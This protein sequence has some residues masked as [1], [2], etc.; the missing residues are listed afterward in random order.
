[1]GMFNTVASI[2]IFARSCMIYAL[3]RGYPLRFSSKNTIL[4]KYDGLFVE[5]F[6]RIYREEF[7]EKFKAIGIDYEH[8][9]IDDMV[10]QAIKG[11][12]GLVWACKNY[13]A[14]VIS[15]IIGQGFGSVGLMTSALVNEKGA[16]LS[17]TAHGTVTRHFR[18]WEQT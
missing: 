18:I 8:R 14:D 9:L 6:D 11:D 17:E 1:M 3:G 12:G 2:D 16:Y 13:D 4:K 15:D 10:A 7:K 5:S